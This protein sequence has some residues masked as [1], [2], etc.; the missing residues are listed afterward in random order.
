MHYYEQIVE[1]LVAKAVAEYELRGALADT[2][3]MFVSDH[4]HTPVIADAAHALEVDDLV[5]AFESV[6][7]D[8]RP[9]ALTVDDEDFTAV[10][11]SQGGLAYVYLADRAD[12][13]EGISCRWQQRPR[14][15]QDVLP[16]VEMLDRY[17][18]E[19]VGLGGKI[20]AVLTRDPRYAGAPF[21]VWE[22]GRLHDVDA[23]LE[24][25]D[26]GHLLEFDR[27]LLE[28]TDGPSG[29]LAG[30]I[31]LVP[32][33]G[34]RYPAA[35]RFYFAKPMTSVHGSATVEDSRFTWLVV[36]PRRSGAE[37][38]RMVEPV[39]AGMARQEHFVPLA[40]HVLEAA[41]ATANARLPRR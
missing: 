21:Q 6:G 1:P 30:E 40:L 9:A 26:M 7:Y 18:G 8:L 10:L 19:R 24:A 25:N 27:R 3:I 5:E 23:W 16:V 36:H 14:W 29:G 33:Y 41:P 17:N 32:H 2:W 39:V 13:P 35:D 11:A 34:M 12:C 28:L 38:Q 4:G 31:I 37:I 20:A 15:E 22:D